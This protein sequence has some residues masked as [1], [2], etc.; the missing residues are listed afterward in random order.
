MRHKTARIV[1]SDL[2][3][4]IGELLQQLRIAPNGWTDKTHERAANQNLQIIGK[5]R[6]DA[7]SICA[8]AGS[9]ASATSRPS[10]RV[11][12]FSSMISAIGEIC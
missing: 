11:A 2:P 8:K 7:Q 5:L 4:N 6:F 3:H 1:K 10:N 9:T 12:E